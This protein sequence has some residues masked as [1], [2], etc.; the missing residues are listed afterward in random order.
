MLN[1]ILAFYRN[2]SLQLYIS[3]P[4]QWFYF[5]VVCHL[6]QQCASGLVCEF[7]MRLGMVSYHAW[8]FCWGKPLFSMGLE[9]FIEIEPKTGIQSCVSGVYEELILH[10]VLKVLLKGGTAVY[11]TPFQVT[12]STQIR[13]LTLILYYSILPHPLQ[14]IL[15][16]HDL[17]FLSTWMLHLLELLQWLDVH[18]PD[19][20]PNILPLILLYYIICQPTTF[21]MSVM[22]KA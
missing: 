21:D 11:R 1:V 17:T 19:T 6:Q 4:V 12:F 20:N 3:D 13:S 9:N 15:V 5:Y 2:I 22:H 14:L 8:T 16:E 10:I 7:V 18:F